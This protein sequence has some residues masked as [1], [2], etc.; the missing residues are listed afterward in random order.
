MA[1][2]RFS[3]YDIPDLLVKREMKKHELQ[4]CID[5]ISDAKEHYRKSKSEVTGISIEKCTVTEHDLAPLDLLKFCLEQHKVKA[6]NN[7]S[8]LHELI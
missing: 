2:Q 1:G 3:F 4:L 6:N 5:F 7:R 8:M